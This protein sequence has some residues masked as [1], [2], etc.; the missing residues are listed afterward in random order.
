MKKRTAING[1]GRIGRLCLRSLLDDPSMEL[2]AVNDVASWEAI[3]YLVRHDTEHG[4]LDP[5]HSVTAGEGCLL[6][7]GREV[8]AFSE[9]DAANLPWA[10][11]GIDLVLECSGAYTSKEKAQ[12][13]VIAGAS[14]VLVSA[15][16][17]GGLPT[18]VFG[19]NEGVILPDDKV[20]SGASCSTVGLT[21][22]AKALNELA[23][24]EHGVSTTIHALTPTQMALDS[25][26]RKGNLRRSRTSGTNI[27]PTTAAAAKA[28]GL[29]VP[30]LAGKLSGS[31]IRV[32]VTRGSYIQLVAS[33]RADA[34][35]AGAVNDWMSS[36]RSDLFGYAEE[37]L[38]SGDIAGTSFESIFDPYQ[39]KVAPLGDG[40]YLVECATWFDNETSYVSH[41]MKLASFMTG[42]SM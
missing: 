31:A 25:P 21:P 15:A 36:M 32:P 13:H 19:V 10:D 2:A 40:R 22:L 27:I 41:F 8:P 35:D 6:V 39:T 24:I 16:C 3:A 26:Q 20:V 12:A 42:G 29:V 34:L 1:I 33:V 37:E 14:R 5:A 11:L 23:P 18:V 30:E 38:V 4:P 7:D 9:A 17:S 28:V